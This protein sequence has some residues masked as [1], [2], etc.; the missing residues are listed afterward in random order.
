MIPT[1]L[2]LE[3]PCPSPQVRS[4][5]GGHVSGP[6]PSSSS[7]DQRRTFDGVPY[8]LLIGENNPWCAASEGLPTLRLNALS[9]LMG[10]VFHIH[11]SAPPK[12]PAGFFALLSAQEAQD[13]MLCFSPGRFPAGA[14]RFCR[15]LRFPTASL[16]LLF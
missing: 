11:K 1:L 3:P 8:F 13:K 16:A 7:S 10:C 4:S 6:S 12:S 2:E 9:F 14:G 15:A 5:P